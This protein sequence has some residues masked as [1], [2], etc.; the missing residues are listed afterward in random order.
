LDIA[1]IIPCFNSA[2]WVGEAIESVLGQTVRPAEIIVVNDGSTD[3]SAEELRTFGSRIRVVDQMNQGPS[4][5]R[6]LGAK[7]AATQWLTFLDAD[8]VYEPEYLA[9]VQSLT[10]AFPAASMLFSEYSNLDCLS[11]PSTMDKYVPEL[12]AAAVEQHGDL[13]CLGPAAA[14]LIIRSNG[15][16]APSCLTVH[17]SLFDQVGGFFEGNRGSE[18]LDFYLHA[19][20]R[21][22]VAI[23]KRKLVRKRNHPACFS[24]NYHAGRKTIDVF[25]QRAQ[26]FCS[27]HWPEMLP[28]VRKKYVGLLLASG[29]SEKQMGMH[30]AACKTYA[31]LIRIDPLRYQN[32]CNYLVC[33]W[34]R[35]FNHRSLN[36]ESGARP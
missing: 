27:Q 2:A 23:I 17:R 5:A 7:L 25:W 20:P 19:L 15:A 33:V 31:R 26:P 28:L 24:N 21:A 9:G 3:K 36:N 29:Q 6:N 1:V 14:H 12:R 8:D 32:W 22:K 34:R 11:L 13:L 16:F 35:L 10:S 4:A 18:D 30:N